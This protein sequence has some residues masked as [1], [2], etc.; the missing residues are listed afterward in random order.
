M[1]GHHKY[2]KSYG[3]IVF[4]IPKFKSS[5]PDKKDWGK[6]RQ[7]KQG[8]Q[9]P[10]CFV[11]SLQ[12]DDIQY[13][14]ICRKHSMGFV[15]LIRGKYDFS[16]PYYIQTMVNLLTLSEKKRLIT[17]SFD[18]LWKQLWNQ[19]QFYTNLKQSTQSKLIFIDAKTKF[20]QLRNG[21][22]LKKQ[23][24]QLSQFI[25]QSTTQWETPEWGFPKG[26]KNKDEYC[27]ECAL[28]EFYEETDYSR[29]TVE[30]LNNT[31][32]FYEIF[33][34]YNKKLYKNIY[35]LGKTLTKQNCVVNYQNKYQK[36]EVSDIKW[37]THSE[38]LQLI[39]PSCKEKIELL[40]KVSK[41]IMYK[42]PYKI[43][44][45]IDTSNKL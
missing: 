36:F 43:C 17:L 22:Q 41:Y 27:K 34:G 8:I 44:G 23:Y 10:K 26:R 9:E 40:E 39:R 45:F 18:I 19:N 1:K 3:I 5:I 25:K 15:E 30:L 32:P 24:Y 37:V 4:T 13:L 42:K 31:K 6:I 20:C 16:Q 38:A 12:P 7:K 28:R 29:D 21:Y 2:I 11:S 33:Q 35:F 14:L